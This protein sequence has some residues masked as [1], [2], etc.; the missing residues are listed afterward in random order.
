M[1]KLADP[2]GRG[3]L[4]FTAEA[5]GQ[6][7]LRCPGCLQVKHNP[8][9]RISVRSLSNSRGVLR[10]SEGRG[11]GVFVLPGYPGRPLD[12]DEPSQEYDD[13]SRCSD[14]L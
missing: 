6:F 12:E 13:L 4:D 2:G 3:T 10:G 9:A 1:L 8:A 14:G 11:R 5:V 7:L